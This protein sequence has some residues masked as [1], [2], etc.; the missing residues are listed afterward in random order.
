MLRLICASRDRRGVVMRR[1]GSDD[2]GGTVPTVYAAPDPDDPEPVRQPMELQLR[3]IQT[4]SKRMVTIHPKCYSSLNKFAGGKKWREWCYPECEGWGAHLQG[5]HGE[6]SGRDPERG[7]ST[8]SD[9][10]PSP[11][12][13]WSPTR[14][15][16]VSLR[17]PPPPQMSMTI[18]LPQC[19]EQRR[20]EVTPPPRR[21]S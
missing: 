8:P 5:D 12:R 10:N 14:H 21:C 9:L 15:K 2:D 4:P 3:R 6:G 19:Q 17:R 20:G 7:L 13:S 1:D 18:D 11:P 16:N